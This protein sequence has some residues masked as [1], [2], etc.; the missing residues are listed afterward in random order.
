M[1]IQELERLVGIERA[2]IRYYE[3]EG[4]I[5]PVRSENG[6]RDYSEADVEELRRIK[7]LRELGVTLETIRQLQQGSADFQ[8]VMAQQ[9][10]ILQGRQQQ[11]ER[12]RTV[13][14]RISADGVSYQQM[15]TARYQNLLA[16]ATLPEPTGQGS[17]STV[18]SET[19]QREVHPWRRFLARFLDHEI[20]TILLWFIIAVILRWRPIYNLQITLLK[21]A[22]W[23]IMVPIEAALLHLWGTTLGKWL[24]GIRVE[25]TEGGKPGYSE[26]L[27]RSWKAFYIGMGCGI[28][29]LRLYCMY[30][31]YKAHTQTVDTDWDLDTGTEMGFRKFSWVNILLSVAFYCLLIGIDHISTVDIALPKY[32]SNELTIAEFARNYNDYN[33]TIYDGSLERMDESGILEEVTYDSFMVLPNEGQLKYDPYAQFEF[34]LEENGTIDTITFRHTWNDRS[35]I[36]EQSGV[37]DSLDC[38]IPQYCQNAI[39]TAIASQEGLD[40]NTLEAYSAQLGQDQAQPASDERTFTYGAVTCTWDLD[41]ETIAVYE[42]D[43]DQL[44]VYEVTLDLKIEFE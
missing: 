37:M 31:G 5:T 16:T 23:F 30:K 29:I 34:Q 24:M 11:M 32:R 7:L 38:W 26:A 22:A 17:G 36:V 20:L 33:Q 42:E 19:V 15:D 2:T 9:C 6:Y 1:R 4:L 21:Y 18:Y 14:Q 40:T 3:K 13:Y 44:D 41:L 10:Q 27:E 28:P 43:S 25:A 39:F 8:A 35:W 12:A